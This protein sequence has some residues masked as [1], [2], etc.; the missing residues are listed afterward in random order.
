MTDDVIR[1]AGSLERSR[2][3]FRVRHGSKPR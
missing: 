1:C 2:K 3:Q